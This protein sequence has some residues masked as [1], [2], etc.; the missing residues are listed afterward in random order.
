MAGIRREPKVLI[1]AVDQLLGAN[2]AYIRKKAALAACR[3]VRKVSHLSA[4]RF[5]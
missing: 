2:Q 3:I 1:P 5:P 4:D